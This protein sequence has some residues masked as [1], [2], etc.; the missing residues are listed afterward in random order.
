MWGGSVGRGGCLGLS[1]GCRGKRLPAS[2]QLQAG[3]AE[4]SKRTKSYGLAWAG[5]EGALAAVGTRC[6]KLSKQVN[7]AFEKKKKKKR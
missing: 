6:V 2:E 4:E 1:P 7:R 5:G 3:A